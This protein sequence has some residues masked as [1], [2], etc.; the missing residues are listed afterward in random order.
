MSPLT[1]LFGLIVSPEFLHA[2][3]RLSTPLLLA[4]LGGLLC[5]RAGVLNIALEGMMLGG[6]L[7]GYLGAYQSGSPWIGLLW[8]VGAG[9][10]VALIFALATVTIGTDQIVAAV[11]INIGM[12]GLTGIVLRSVFGAA[13]GQQPAPTFATMPLPGLAALPTIG[14]LLF[15]HL[16]L[17]YL[18][19]TLAPAL[20]LLLA[21]TTW[22]LA[23]R[24]VGEKPRAADTVGINVARVRYLTV[25]WS[26]AL[27]ATGGALLSIGYLNT[28]VEG[29]TAG[30]GFIA[31]AAIIFGRYTALGTLSAALL[32]GAA[33]ALQ[34][35]IQALDLVA[36]PYQLLVMLPYLVTLLALFL[37]GRGAAPAAQGIPYRREL[38]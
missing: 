5:E 14:P 34:L 15:N 1:D 28:F 35:R 8:A 7:F 26:G 18:A 31:F 29:I 21:R 20:H 10:T 9:L 12:L 36:L 23:I 30:R 6:A 11:A 25:L 17:V 37:A 32:F 24:A 38:T 22:G 19:F 13:S 27:A 16:A 4:A 3:I 33:D 2:T